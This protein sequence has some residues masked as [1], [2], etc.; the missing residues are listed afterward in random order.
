ME[1]QRMMTVGMAMPSKEQCF[2][3]KK[4]KKCTNDQGE[5]PSPAEGVGSAPTS[6]NLYNLAG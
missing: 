2:R 1:T 6:S 4:R 5:G 3:Q